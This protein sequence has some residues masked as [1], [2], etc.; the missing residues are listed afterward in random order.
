[1]LLSYYVTDIKSLITLDIYTGKCYCPVI[2][3]RCCTLGS[4]VADAIGHCG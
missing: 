2:S 1:M 4:S 3:G